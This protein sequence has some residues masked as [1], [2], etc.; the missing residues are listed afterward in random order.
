MNAESHQ[1]CSVRE[2]QAKSL[3]TGLRR[4]ADGVEASGVSCFVPCNSLRRYI[5]PKGQMKKPEARALQN[6]CPR[7]DAANP[8]C[9]SGGGAD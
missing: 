4:D 3:F 7:L 1:L 2:R 5:N 8:F 6:R 9:C